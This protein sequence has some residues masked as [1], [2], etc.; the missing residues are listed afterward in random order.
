MKTKYKIGSMVYLLTDTTQSIRIV[1]GIR[2]TI[3]ETMYEL[4]CGSSASNHYEFEMHDS[5][6][7]LMQ[8]L[9]ND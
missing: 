2:I 1:T 6:D 4:S 9:S 7:C 5:K 8:I 3:G